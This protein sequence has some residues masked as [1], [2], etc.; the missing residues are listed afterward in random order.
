[1]PILGNQVRVSIACNS[2]KHCSVN[3]TQTSRQ[4][5]VL[6][7]VGLSVFQPIE[8]SSKRMSPRRLVYKHGTVCTRVYSVAVPRSV[9][10]LYHGPTPLYTAPFRYTLLNSTEASRREIELRYV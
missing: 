9:L 6:P 3:H 2:A 5:F 8:R 7:K 10:G 1:M 4:C